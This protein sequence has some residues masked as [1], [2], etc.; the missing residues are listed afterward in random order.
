MVYFLLSLLVLTD[1]LNIL[2]SFLLAEKVCLLSFLLILIVL[3]IIVF[4]L[5]L[6]VLFCL[7]DILLTLIVLF[8]TIFDITS[9]DL[10]LTILQKLLLTLKTY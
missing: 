1:L 6:V 3:S 8:I 4:D 5:Y 9:F 10:N 2:L 7:L